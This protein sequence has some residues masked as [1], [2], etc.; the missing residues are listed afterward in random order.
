[1]TSFDEIFELFL[2][3]I[4]EYDLSQLSDDLMEEELIS[5]L[6]SAYIK[7]GSNISNN[8]VIDYSSKTLSNPDNK[9]NS[10]TP[11]EINILVFWMLDEWVEPFVNNE[12][13]LKM[14]LASQDY[15]E[16]SR[17]NML[18][19]ITKA[20]NDIKK[21]ALRYTHIYGFRKGFAKRVRNKQ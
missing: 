8:I 2:S 13:V 17:A 20:K 19:K 16:L 4:T 14:G 11:I 5:I 12:E 18:D 10:L 15:K 9:T 7:L 21:E 3:K 1:M 6:K